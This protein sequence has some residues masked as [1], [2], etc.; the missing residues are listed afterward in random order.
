MQGFFVRALVSNVFKET[1]GEPIV[2]GVDGG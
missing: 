1:R 2:Q